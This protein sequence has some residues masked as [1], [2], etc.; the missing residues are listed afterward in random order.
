MARISGV[1]G[2]K[3]LLK[4]GDGASPEQFVAKCSINA[5]RGLQL[6]TATNESIDIDCD[7][8]DALAW[9]D[10]EKVSL[11]A[12]INGAGNIHTDDIE[13]FFDWLTSTESKN[14][15]FVVDV[16]AASGGVVF[17]GFFHLTDFE[18][19]G[20]RGAKADCSITLASDGEVTLV[21]NT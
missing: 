5:A 4:V 15:Q 9:I 21:P 7:D 18:I 20:D 17:E 13:D 16:P 10:R 12:S 6:T 11:S 1:R 14:C 3:L 2:T 8:P 19:T